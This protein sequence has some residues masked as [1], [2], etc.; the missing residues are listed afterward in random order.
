MPNPYLQMLPKPPAEDRRE[1]VEL[2]RQFAEAL[3]QYAGQGT[4]VEVYVAVH[5][6]DSPDQIARVQLSVYV[7]KTDYANLVLVARCK[8]QNGYPVTLDPYFAGSTFPTGILPCQ[9]RQ[10]LDEALNKFAQSQEVL[11]LLEYMQRHARK[12]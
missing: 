8:G 3:Q 2:L 6:E 10:Q 7:P 9:N 12:R 5:P 1:P 11:G 4:D